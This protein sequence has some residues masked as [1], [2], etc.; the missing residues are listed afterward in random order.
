[1]SKRIVRYLA[2]ALTLSAFVLI[3]ASGATTPRANAAADFA[4]DRYLVKVQ[5]G[6]DM[7]AAEAAVERAGGQVSGSIPQ[8]NLLIVS[9]A[10]QGV[11]EALSREATMFAGMARDGIKS[12]VTPNQQKELW[13]TEPGIRKA[14]KIKIANPRES[15]REDD[16]LPDPSYNLPET[17][18][19]T[20]RVNAVK[21]WEE[22]G[23]S[24]TDAIIVAVADTGIDYTHIDLAD[25]VIDVND[26]TYLE[27][28][29]NICRDFFGGPTDQELADAFGGPASGDWNGHGSWI[30]GNIAGVLNETGMN[31]IAPNVR[32]V[33]LKI[34]Q[35]CGSAFD[36]EILAAIAT[37][38][39]WQIDVVNISFGGFQSRANPEGEFV[40][41][42]YREVVR[43]ANAKGTM[44]V[45][46]AGNDHVEVG[47]H[48]KVKSH[49]TLT[50]PGDDLFD[51]FGLYVTPGGIPGVVMVSALGNVTAAASP[52]CPG[53]TAEGP[54]ATCKPASDAHQPIAAGR[55]DQLTYYS[56]YGKRINLSAPGGARKFNLPSADRGG[57]PGFPVTDA[58]GTLPFQTFSVT[59]NWSV[60]TGQI[61]CFDLSSFPGFT[62][63]CYTSIQGTSM[64][65]PHVAGVM[66]QVLSARPDLRKAPKQLLAHVAAAA[67]KDLRNKTPGLSPTDTSPGDR[68]GI[69]CPTGSCHLGGP[70]ISNDKA[71]G[72]GMVDAYQAIIQ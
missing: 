28:P 67:R 37:A 27:E 47:K 8:L 23:G 43:Y 62:D 36:S 10:N 12:L 60:Y 64:S 52:S 50:N 29:Y 17:M 56:N 68:T 7:A 61:P 53:D 5:K 44:I 38:G 2:L 40:W 4:S 69:D 58:D 24:G 59:S 25:N 71:Y 11:R 39:D 6:V 30:A 26:F 16:I 46:S 13:G 70:A 32:L 34:S 3:A 55:Y 1:M 42:Q 18:W 35:W 63:Q 49:G 22:F 65:A 31:G 21:G 33:A 9:R 19:S 54:N 72:D 51:P 14:E 45:A 57:T 41:Q 66:A 48:G 20:Y 15:A